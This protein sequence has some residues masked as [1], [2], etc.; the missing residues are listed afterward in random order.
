MA[1]EYNLIAQ[2]QRED[3]DQQC[4]REQPVLKLVK[5]HVL[6]CL[7][8]HTWVERLPQWYNAELGKGWQCGECGTTSISIHEGRP[9]G[10]RS[11]RWQELVDEFE[12]YY[13]VFHKDIGYWDWILSTVVVKHQ[14]GEE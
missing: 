12:E 10:P 11:Q 13:E 9:F 6:R 14:E 1:V 2:E 3:N 8:C 4:E 5:S 7:G